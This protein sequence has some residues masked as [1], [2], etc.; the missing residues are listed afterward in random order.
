M[1]T[2]QIPLFEGGFD[3]RLAMP[4]RELLSTSTLLMAAIGRF[5]KGDDVFYAKVVD[6][7]LF[8]LQGDVF[9]SPSYEKKPTST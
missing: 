9:G 4:L 5:Q 3:F 8:R 1:A 2:A 6:G 7:E